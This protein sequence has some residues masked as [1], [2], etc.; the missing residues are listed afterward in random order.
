MYEVIYKFADMLDNNHVYEVGNTYP[1]DGYGPTEE[2]I[3]ELAGAS[4]KIGKP[5]IREIA[6]KEEPVE[7][8]PK[9]KKRKKVDAE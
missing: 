6:V 2:R 4:N 7:E 3:K 8:E 5:L 1:R 9:P